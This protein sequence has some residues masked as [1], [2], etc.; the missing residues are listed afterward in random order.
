[1]NSRLL[2]TTVSLLLFGVIL[3]KVDLRE[4]LTLIRS[5]DITSVGGVLV[6]ALVGILISTWKWS[7]LL[8]VI[9]LSASYTQLLRLFWIGVFFNNLLPGRTG[10]DLIRAYGIGQDA[11]NR[12]EAFLSVAI[13]RGL[14]LM[15][16]FGIAILALLVSPGVLPD[17]IRTRLLTWS[18]GLFAGALLVLGIGL[19]LSRRISGRTRIGHL[20]AELSTAVARLLR[21][22]AVCLTAVALSAGYQATVI[23]SNFTIARGLGLDVTPGAFF[24]LIP[25][26][27]LITLLPISLNGLGLREGAY[28]LVFTQIGVT[29]EAAVAISI[30]ATACMVGISL[31]GGILYI[32]GPSRIQ[33]QLEPSPPPDTRST[34]SLAPVP[35]GIAAEYDRTEAAG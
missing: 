14:N 31:V 19:H 12:T 9:R 20:L 8:G 29:A 27:A 10:G 2:K 25:I 34:A 23:L 15:A 28:A 17:L 22:P 33:I 3:W 4:T 18:A 7:M 6:L 16:L 35:E 13:D 26:T 30:A 1:M 21:R 32:T 24:Y 5:L 11:R